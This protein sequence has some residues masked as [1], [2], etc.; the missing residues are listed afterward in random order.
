MSGV[1]V[2]VFFVLFLVVDVWEALRSIFSNK[3][4][5]LEWRLHMRT[6]VGANGP[7]VVK[8]LYCLLL[9]VLLTASDFG[10]TVEERKKTKLHQYSQNFA[11]EKRSFL[12]PQL[13]FELV[14]L[15]SKRKKSRFR[16]KCQICLFPRV[17]NMPIS[18]CNENYTNGGRRRRSTTQKKKVCSSR[19]N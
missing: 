9:R 8:Y 7:L 15:L 13:P 18:T 16:G 19:A 14:I 11:L 4:G 2:S 3:Q 10:T 1:P 12:N 17:P 6:Q 5:S